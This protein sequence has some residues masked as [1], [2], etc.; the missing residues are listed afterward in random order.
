LDPNRFDALARALTTTQSR[1]G[2]ACLLGGLTLGGLT[3]FGAAEVEAGTLI[4]GSPC[5]KDT[6]CKTGKCLR[7]NT[8]SCSREFPKCKRPSNPCKRAKCDVSKDR[9]VATDKQD[10][11]SCGTGLVCDNGECICTPASCPNGCCLSRKTCVLRPDQTNEQCGT[12]GAPCA[13]CLDPQVCCR[14]GCRG[15][16]NATCTT[17]ADC[18]GVCTEDP[19]ASTKVCCPNC[20]GGCICQ[21]TEEGDVAC[22]NILQS[23]DPCIKSSTC[24]AGRACFG[25]VCRNVCPPA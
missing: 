17:N 11:T 21:K 8:C 20:P 1:R 22:A 23:Y 9:C 2:L 10:G 4:G 6:Q 5:T 24:G 18:C 13:A 15:A 19:E 12:G 7:N 3:A 25:G 16:P 14:G